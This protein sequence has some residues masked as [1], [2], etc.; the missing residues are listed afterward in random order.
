MKKQTLEEWTTEA[1]TEEQKLMGVDVV[2]KSSIWSAKDQEGQ[3]EQGV[4][5]QEPN[6][7]REPFRFSFTS[8]RFRDVVQASIEKSCATASAPASVPACL[9]K[10]K[11]V[12]DDSIVSIVDSASVEEKDELATLSSPVES[13]SLPTA[14]DDMPIKMPCPKLSPPSSILIM[15]VSDIV[16]DIDT[17]TDTDADIKNPATDHPDAAAALKTLTSMFP[18][19]STLPRSQSAAA[20]YDFNIQKSAPIS[21]FM[22]HAPPPRA[23]SS[24]DF[25]DQWIPSKSVPATPFSLPLT[26]PPT[27]PRGPKS[28]VG[29]IGAGGVSASKTASWTSLHKLMHK[30]TNNEAMV[31]SLSLPRRGRMHLDGS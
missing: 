14:E 17:S 9:E 22:P 30:L 19:V 24:I 8:Q 16:S 29:N 13:S 4:P 7:R 26:T 12:S 5:Q 23:A 21:P 18:K 15:A 6:S 31:A 28:P 20:R 3:E 10:T 27:S 2:A 25:V 11:A 1:Q